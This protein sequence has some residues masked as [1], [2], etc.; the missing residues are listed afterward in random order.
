MVVSTMCVAST[1]LNPHRASELPNA[2]KYIA[3]VLGVTKSDLPTKLRKM[4]DE[5]DAAVTAGSASDKND[6]KDKKDKKDRKHGRD[7]KD[8]SDKKA[9]KK[10]RKDPGNQPDDDMP[11]TRKQKK[12][13]R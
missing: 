12:L 6:K 8:K 4:V 13:K 7:S 11:V 10:S 3:S 9:S 5:A 2:L 1:F